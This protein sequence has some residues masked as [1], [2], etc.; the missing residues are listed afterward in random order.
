MALVTT[1]WGT[2]ELL[3]KAVVT[4]EQIDSVGWLSGLAVGGADRGTRGKG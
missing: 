4:T 2:A 1:A 3:I